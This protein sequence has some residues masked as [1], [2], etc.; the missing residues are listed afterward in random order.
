MSL[1]GSRNCPRVAIDAKLA[2]SD[3]RWVWSAGAGIALRLFAAAATAASLAACMQT[4]TANNQSSLAMRQASLHQARKV[5][6]ASKRH[7]AGHRSPFV[8][9][10]QASVAPGD[11]ASGVASFYSHGQQTANGERFNPNEL[12]AAH[13]SLPFGTKVRVTNLNNGQSVTVR[14]NDRGPYVAGRSIDVSHS[15]AQSLG[16]VGQGVAK[17]KMD[18]VQ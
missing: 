4:P 17:V 8:R 3:Q 1:N 7:V 10:R 15:A 12:T 11:S 14:I 2:S 16:M 18:V 9:T 5:A 6:Y 13:R